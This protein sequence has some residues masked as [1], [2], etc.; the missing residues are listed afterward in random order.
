MESARVMDER[1]MA[2]E[3]EEVALSAPIPIPKTQRISTP[4]IQVVHSFAGNSDLPVVPS[5]ASEERKREPGVIT[6]E[7]KTVPI[8]FSRIRLAPEPVARATTMRLDEVIICSQQGGLLK[9]EGSFNPQRRVDLLE[10]F[11]IKMRQISGRP[12]WGEMEFLTLQGK[13][14]TATVEFPDGKG[15]FGL[16]KRPKV[17]PADIRAAVATAVH[18][19]PIASRAS[20]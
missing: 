2:E 1:G 13:D 18:L 11:S 4:R 17:A 20:A 6:A 7:K 19:P 12:E 14:Y 8:E 9:Q 3:D 15:A 5:Y 10:L 16:V